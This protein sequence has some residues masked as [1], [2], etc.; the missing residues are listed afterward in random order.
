MRFQRREP[1][2]SSYCWFGKNDGASGVVIS[3]YTP[4]ARPY[5]TLV[6]EVS[7]TLQLFIVPDISGDA[8][9]RIASGQSAILG[10]T[11]LI[12]P[13]TSHLPETV[14]YGTSHVD[15]AMYVETRGLQRMLQSRAAIESIA[16]SRRWLCYCWIFLR[17]LGRVKAAPFS[18]RLY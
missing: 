3:F 4:V 12:H 18:V 7:C 8:S 16:E 15:V 11:P 17:Y 14:Y 9:R 2:K 13:V 10:I 6:L 5:P 1:Q